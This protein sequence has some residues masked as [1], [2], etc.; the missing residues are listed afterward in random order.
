MTSQPEATATFTGPQNLISHI[1]GLQ[2]TL[3]KRNQQIENQ[4]AQI[5]ALQ[6]AQ[7]QSEPTQEALKAA[8]RKGY[9]AAK[10][11]VAKDL[12]SAQKAINAARLA[13]WLTPLEPTED[14]EAGQ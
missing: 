13:T 5:T 3:T 4:A 9:T 8:W 2:A 1:E 7:E 6:E 14:E 12:D 11:A 10:K